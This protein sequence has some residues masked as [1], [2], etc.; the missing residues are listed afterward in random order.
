[1]KLNNGQ[2]SRTGVRLREL[3]HAQ[4][5]SQ[6]VLAVAMT[7]RG[8]SWHQ[9]TVHRIEAGMRPMRFDEAR[10]LAEIFGVTLESLAGEVPS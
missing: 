2:L 1:V 8:F 7:Q 5:Y 9:V 3:R 10:S 6:E 4:R